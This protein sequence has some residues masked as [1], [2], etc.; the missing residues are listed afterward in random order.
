M[1]FIPAESIKEDQVRIY[2]NKKG[3]RD[4]IDLQIEYNDGKFQDT[5][6]KMYFHEW[7][8]KTIPY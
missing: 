2:R 3:K 8:E 4:F 6:S 5:R 1:F 7:L